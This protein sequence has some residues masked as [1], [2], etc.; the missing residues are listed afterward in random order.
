[1]KLATITDKDG[2]VTV[3]VTLEGKQGEYR[4]DVVEAMTIGEWSK[5]IATPLATTEPNK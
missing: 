1:M 4:G 5:L 3:F 2:N